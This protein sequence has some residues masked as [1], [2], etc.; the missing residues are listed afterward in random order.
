MVQIVWH[1]SQDTGRVGISPHSA[2]GSGDASV[3]GFG[4]AAPTAWPYG[5]RDWA[6]G[7]HS[8]PMGCT[9]EEGARLRHGMGLRQ[10]GGEMGHRRVG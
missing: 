9:W 3:L 5:G 8:G 2:G 10:V 4:G 1:G 6:C 7:G